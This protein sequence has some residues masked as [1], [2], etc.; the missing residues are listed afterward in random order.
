M[1][2]Y[3]TAGCCD[4]PGHMSN[5]A[6]PDFYPRMKLDLVGCA[7]NIKNFLFTGGLW[8]GRVMDP[9]LMTRELA[10]PRSGERTPS[11]HEMRSTA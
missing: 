11:T 2:R 8:N 1:A 10:A 6:N 4:S 5:R 9:A 7:Q 3:V